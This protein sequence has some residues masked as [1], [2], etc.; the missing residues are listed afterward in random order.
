MSEFAGTLRERILVERQVNLRPA[1]GLQQP[2][3]KPVARCLAAIQ[4]DGVGPEAEAGALSS[5]PRFRV[6]IRRR[7]GVSI[8]HRIRWR[9][10]SMMVTQRIDDP[11]LPD[12]VLLRCEE[13]R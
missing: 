7:E 12:R 10:R 9:G 3:W 1:S 5:M 4:A 2:G 13:M 6:T 11:L 8:G